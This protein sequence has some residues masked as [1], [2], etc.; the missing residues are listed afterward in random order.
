[1]S[2]LSLWNSLAC[3]YLLPGAWIAGL[4]QPH[5][6]E[7][8]SGDNISISCHRP[9]VLLIYQTDQHIKLLHLC[10]YYPVECSVDAAEYTIP[11]HCLW[12]SS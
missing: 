6:V 11:V 3:W 2:L 1:M 4:G 5:R 8:R 12:I 7:P 10:L 9:L